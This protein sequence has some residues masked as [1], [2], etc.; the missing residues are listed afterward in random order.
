MNLLIQV[1]AINGVIIEKAKWIVN[2]YSYI[3]E[4]QS[5]FIDISSDNQKLISYISGLNSQDCYVEEGEYQTITLHFRIKS[6]RHSFDTTQK[7]KKIETMISV[8]PVNRMVENII[9]YVYEPSLCDQKFLQVL[10][11]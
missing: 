2:N 6:I 1:T 5:I 9:L 11:N 8:M 10:R 4:N 3:K 7:T